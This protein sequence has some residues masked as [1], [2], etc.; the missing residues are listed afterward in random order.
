MARDHA[1]HFWNEAGEAVDTTSRD[2]SHRA[3]GLAA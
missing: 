2:L 1:V 3:Q